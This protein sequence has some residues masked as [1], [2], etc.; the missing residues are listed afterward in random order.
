MV[1]LRA[2]EMAAKLVVKTAASMVGAMVCSTAE[3]MEQK[4]SKMAACWAGMM[5]YLRA[6][7]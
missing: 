1:F 6:V 7:N 4:V 5:A 3:T 2:D